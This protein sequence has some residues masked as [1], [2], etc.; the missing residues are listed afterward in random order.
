MK[1]INGRI[2]DIVILGL[3]WQSAISRTRSKGH[4]NQATGVE[5]LELSHGLI[6]TFGDR[7][8]GLPG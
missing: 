3:L 2:L 6:D 5:L 1:D 4:P 7:V 8:Q